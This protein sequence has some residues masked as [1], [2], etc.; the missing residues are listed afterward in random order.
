MHAAIQLLSRDLQLLI[1]CLLGDDANPAS[2]QLPVRLAS[3]PS[4]L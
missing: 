1:L 4:G 3:L 2:M